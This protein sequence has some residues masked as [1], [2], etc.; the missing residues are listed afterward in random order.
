[1]LGEPDLA[2]GSQLRQLGTTCLELRGEDL[3]RG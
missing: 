2:R 3:V 1:V